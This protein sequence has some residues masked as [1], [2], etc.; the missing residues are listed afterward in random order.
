MKTHDP[1]ID[2][3]E[4]ME[5]EDEDYNTSEYPIE[6]E[7]D[8]EAGVQVWPWPPNPADQEDFIDTDRDIESEIK[9][10]RAQIT[11]LPSLEHQLGEPSKMVPQK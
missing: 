4:E 5:K 9:E 2:V 11:L 8:S 6:H 1:P 7:K 10:Q 3:K